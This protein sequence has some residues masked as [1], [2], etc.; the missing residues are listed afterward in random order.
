MS[1]TKRVTFT[2]L[3]KP[4]MDHKG[5]EKDSSPIHSLILTLL[6]QP[7]AHPEDDK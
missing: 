4:L 1:S 3:G 6:R 7:P 2:E 5:Q